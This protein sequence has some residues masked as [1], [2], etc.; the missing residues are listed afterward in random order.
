MLC[1]TLFVLLPLLY[2]IYLSFTSFSILRPNSQFVG[3]GN[4]AQLGADAIQ[5]AAFTASLLFALAGAA[6]SLPFG[7]AAAWVFSQDVLLV[8]WLRAA[9]STPFVVA[10]ALAGVLAVIFMN[11]VTGAMPFVLDEPSNARIGILLVDAWRWTPLICLVMIVVLARARAHGPLGTR[12]TLSKVGG[13]LAA[14]MLF[15]IIEGLKLFD[16]PYAM[17]SGGPASATMTLTLYA[18]RTSFLQFRLGYAAAM[19]V[20]LLLI[21]LGLTVVL[22]WILRRTK[23]WSS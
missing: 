19:A 10:P 23:L 16:L 11:P 5:G 18:W 17:T 22:V 14:L 1:I 15:R 21:I 12:E 6:I 20:L 13:P 2:G 4:Y 9:F 3:F 8:R 7:L